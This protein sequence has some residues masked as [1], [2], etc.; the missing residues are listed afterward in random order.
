MVAMPSRDDVP[1]VVDENAIVE[2]YART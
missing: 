2:F 1:L